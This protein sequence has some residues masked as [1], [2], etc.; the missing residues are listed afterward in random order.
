MKTVA[1]VQARMG[2]TRLPGKIMKIL[3]GRTVLGH[4]LERCRAI[5]SVDQVIVATTD[6]PE[7]EAVCQEAERSGVEFYRGSSGDV[8][9]RYYHAAQTSQADIIVRVTS[10]CPLLDPYISNEVILDFQRGAYDYS[11]SEGFPRGMD[12]EVFTFRVLEQAYCEAK[13]DYEHEH[14]TPYLY[15]HPEK[16]DLRTFR[17]EHDNS[18]YRLTLDTEEDWT[19]ISQIYERLHKGG[20]FKLADVLELLKKEPELALINGH[21]VQKRLGE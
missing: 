13:F 3:A 10:D 21:I 6:L 15:R 18:E 17:S 9:S 16:F 5:P 19:L 2:S 11:S 12:T 8:L 20:I 4:V 14:V 7:D 1:I